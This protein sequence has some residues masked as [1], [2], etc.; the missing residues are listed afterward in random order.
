MDYIKLVGGLILLIISGDYLVRGG[1]AIATRLKISS[2]VIGMTVIAFGTSAPEFLVSLQAALKG[3]S[4]IAI[5]NVVGSNI[6][7]I[8][9][10]LGLTALV[11]PLKV[12]RNSIRFDWP[13]MMI[14]TL[15]FTWAASG[16]EI[17][18]VEGIIGV[19]GLVAYTA[20]QIYSS[21]KQHIPE[22]EAVKKPISVWL[23]LLF[24]AGS[25]VGLAYGADFLIQGAS[26][27][28]KS[29]GISE[30]VIG[31]TIVA[32]GTSLPE[33]AASLAAAF[34]KQTDIAIGN[35]IGSNLFN[36]LSVI[37][38]TAAIRPIPVDW[39]SFKP[40]FYWMCAISFLLIFL[41][42]PMRAAFSLRGLPMR[43]KINALFM[44]GRLGRGGGIL[45]VVIYI[46]YIYTLLI[47]G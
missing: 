25:C 30:R 43:S 18:R 19:I 37:G 33:L 36:I 31:V 15:L 41:V 26:N 5:G 16:M 20:W 13:T 4:E 7:N 3:S 23:A 24:I 35:I 27:I 34:K 44:E 12:A 22:E 47:H 10:I 32:F 11:Y 46:F 14:A 1:V 21:R 42:L 39:T 17:T 38:L 45:F 28:A 2:L 8:A 6:A 29:F 40:D 9:L